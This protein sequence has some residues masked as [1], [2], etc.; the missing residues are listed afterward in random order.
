MRIETTPAEITA[1]NR[2]GVLQIDQSLTNNALTG[3]KPEDFWKRIY[4]QY[5]EVA[6]QNMQKIVEEG[7]Q[8]GDLRRKDNPLA[9]LALRQ[10]IEGAPD[11][12]VYGPASPANIR[13]SYTPN[14]INLQVQVGGAEIDVQT[15]R[16]EIQYVPGSVQ[17]Y[18]KQYPQVIITPPAI[19]I[20]V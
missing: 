4:A 16:P 13:F 6:L 1:N 20:S 3:G 2:P 8:M 19:D 5:R 7:N 11:L 14:D 9:D 10:Y 12:Q 17:I 15:F 18:M